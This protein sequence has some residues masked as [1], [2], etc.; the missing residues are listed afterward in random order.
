VDEHGR[1]SWRRVEVTGDGVFDGM[2][3]E[4][5]FAWK[6]DIVTE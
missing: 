4:R 2:A 3:W 5:V 6:G 1:E